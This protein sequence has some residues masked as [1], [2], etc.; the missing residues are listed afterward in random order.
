MTEPRLH[1]AAAKLA[2]AKA[3]RGQPISHILME[4]GHVAPSDMLGAMAQAT[5]IGQPV[6]QVVVADFIASREDV[7][8]AQAQHFGAMVLK[9]DDTPPDPA[10]MDLLPPEFCLQHGV[11]PWMRVG[12]GTR[13]CWPPRARMTFRRCCISC[14]PT[15]AR[16]S[17]RWR[18]RRTFTT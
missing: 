4:D 16:W 2:Q 14:R 9:R 6:P 17:W 1:L 3:R 12:W 13:C 5:R 10:V 11:L 7:L 15:L 8:D 18:W